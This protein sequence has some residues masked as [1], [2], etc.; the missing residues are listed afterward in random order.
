MTRKRTLILLTVT[1]AESDQEYWI[2]KGEENANKNLDQWPQFVAALDDNDPTSVADELKFWQSQVADSVENMNEFVPKLV[3]IVDTINSTAAGEPNIF[4]R[5][6]LRAIL[7]FIDGKRDN[8]SYYLLDGAF[9][10]IQNRRSALNAGGE[11][12]NDL[13]D[14]LSE[15]LVSIVNTRDELDSNAQRFVKDI[16]KIQ[17]LASDIVAHIEGKL[18]D[19]HTLD[20]GDNSLNDV[21][22]RNSFHRKWPVESITKL[23]IVTE[24]SSY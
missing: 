8:K 23:L 6:E 3:W 18:D 10:W 12:A 2:R 9:N 20:G 13:A 22:F 24:C 21:H 16:A 17:S 4:R 14:R 15:A 5:G 7:W 1:A 11:R 19:N